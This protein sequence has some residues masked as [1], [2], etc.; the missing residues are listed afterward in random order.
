MHELV[1]IIGGKFI[2]EYEFF[3]YFSPFMILFKRFNS[4]NISS[5][6]P[7]IVG[8]PEPAAGAAVRGGP[9]SMGRAGAAMGAAG[10]AGRAGRAMGAAGARGGPAIG[11][12]AAGSRGSPAAGGRGGP[13]AGGRGGP[14]AGGR[15]GP[16][17]GLGAATALGGVIACPESKAINFSR[18]DDEVWVPAFIVVKTADLSAPLL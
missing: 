7:E 18:D 1:N 10:A 12:A 14:A 4:F 15:G 16:A 17:A 11:G 2:R 9:A 5:R 13:A 6:S 8:A 3:S